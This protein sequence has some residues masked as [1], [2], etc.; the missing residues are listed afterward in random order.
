[1]IL[2]HRLILGTLRYHDNVISSNISQFPLS[3]KLKRNLSY[4][5]I[6]NLNYI[7]DMKYLKPNP[8]FYKNCHE[9]W[10]KNL[11]FSSRKKNQTFSRQ[12][13]S[14]D[15]HC[16][17]LKILRS[18]N[19][20]YLQ[21][22]RQCQKHSD[23]RPT[24]APSEVKKEDCLQNIHSKSVKDHKS[25]EVDTAGEIIERENIWTIPNFLCISRIVL[26][27]Y[28]CYCVL[29][30]H[31]SFALGLFIF[32]GFTDLLDGMIARKFPSQAS[33]IGSFLDPLADKILVSSLFLTLTYVGVI[34]FLLTGIIVYRDVI[35]IAGASYVRYQ[36]IPPPV[37][38]TFLFS[39]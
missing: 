4:P 39:I 27:P 1:M 20:T 34:P 13:F 7:S 23:S 5:I 38:I 36:S 30:S 31:Y 12:I 11:Q 32:A 8:M 28:L 16:F 6:S 35:I 25:K 9:N 24:Y 26:S 33:R 19:S 3:I 2:R 15:H 14:R 10:W 37:S 21:S 17:P 29:S 18:C 22:F